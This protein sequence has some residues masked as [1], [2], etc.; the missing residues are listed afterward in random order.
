MCDQKLFL[1]VASYNHLQYKSSFPASGAVSLYK[2][3]CGFAALYLEIGRLRLTQPYNKRVRMKRYKVDQL[4]FGTAS[5]LRAG[6]VCNFSVVQTTFVASV[7]TENMK[8][9]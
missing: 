2:I 6:A 3:R 4:D 5:E 1:A 7:I 9:I 8:N